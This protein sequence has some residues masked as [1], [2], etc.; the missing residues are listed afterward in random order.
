MIGRRDSIRMAA[1]TLTILTA[2]MSM[3]CG[4]GGGGSSGGPPPMTGLAATFTPNMTNPPAGSISMAAGSASGTVFR[5]DIM[6]TDITDF[7]GAAFPV[8]FDTATASF[9][10]H[11]SSGSFID[12]GGAVLDMRAVPSAGDPGVILVVAT[13]QG[14]TVGG[15]SAVGS[16]KLISLVFEADS[17][18]GGNQFRFDPTASMREA[19]ACAAGVP[20]PAIAVSWHGGTLTAN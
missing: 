11:D 18:T 13:R 8:T 12:Q 5:V 15:V 6:V 7:F 9:L 3:A 2:A 14:A 4:G 19:R 20:C 1:V 16:Q 10:S 17:A